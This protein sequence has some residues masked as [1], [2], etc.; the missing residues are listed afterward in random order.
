[1]IFLTDALVRYARR[2]FR[3][4]PGDC[5]AGGKHVLSTVGDGQL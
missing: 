4:E 5:H 1:V 3:I 2:E